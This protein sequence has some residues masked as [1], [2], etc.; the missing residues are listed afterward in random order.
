MKLIA[1]G[2]ILIDFLQIQ[3]EQGLPTFVAQ[4]GGAPANVICAAAKLGVDGAFIGKVGQ[5]QFGQQLIDTL[6][7]H[8]VETKCIVK[9]EQYPTTLAFVHIDED[10]D[11]SF[12]FYREGSADTK[13]AIENIDPLYFSECRLFHFGSNSFTS[14]ESEAATKRAIELAKA[15]GAI[16]SFDPNVRVKLWHN[17]ADIKPAIESVLPAVDILKVSQEELELLTGAD[18]DEGIVE[19]QTKYDLQLIVVTLGAKGLV[20]RM[21]G[22]TVYIAGYHVVTIDTTGAG[23]SFVGAM[24]AKIMQA[25][26]VL[27]ELNREEIHQALIFANAAAALSTTKNGG[28]P[29][30]P[31]HEQVLD[32][33]HRYKR[34]N[35]I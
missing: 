6:K 8:N 17:S 24:L 9:S 13:L 22:E 1:L 2:E 34:P 26:K 7:Q 29:S 10:G 23:D 19:L 31:T 4:P 25:P 32:F 15:N 27:T 33:L 21:N 16:I 28:I 11:R 3:N 5:D 12:S 30:L 20:Y 35:H 18:I 14:A